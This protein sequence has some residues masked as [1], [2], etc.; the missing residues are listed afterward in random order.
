MLHLKG[1]SGG[2][3]T[4]MDEKN[5]KFQLTFDKSVEKVIYPEPDLGQD[6]CDEYKVE[7]IILETLPKKYIDFK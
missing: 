1:D 5:P 7:A 3:L 4:V 6:C 2:P